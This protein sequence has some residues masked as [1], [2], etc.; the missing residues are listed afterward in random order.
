MRHRAA[1][2]RGHVRVSQQRG[3]A[4]QDCAVTARLASQPGCTPAKSRSTS[5]K[6]PALDRSP[7]LQQVSGNILVKLKSGMW[8]NKTW[9]LVDFTGTVE[10]PDHLGGFRT[11]GEAMT[12][13]EL[14]TICTGP[15]PSV[16]GP[17]SFHTEYDLATGRTT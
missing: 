5:T 10:V 9:R 13:D 6:A 14:A 2:S 17:R 8:T 16:V 4:A 15:E 7:K 12:E 3:C 11:R 1:G